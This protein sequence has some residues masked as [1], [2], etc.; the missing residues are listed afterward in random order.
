MMHP[1][2]ILTTKRIRHA[3]AALL[4]LLLSTVTAQALDLPL[5]KESTRIKE[6]DYPKQVYPILIGP[7]GTDSSK[8][9]E[10]NAA[11]RLNIWRFTQN[12]P[13]YQLSLIWREA[14]EAQGFETLYNCAQR[15]CGGYDF[16]RQLDLALMPDLPVDLR[17][18]AYLAMEGE[19]GALTLFFAGIGEAQRVALS[20][21][22]A[23]TLGDEPPEAAAPLRTIPH[24]GIS[25]PLGLQGAGR[26]VL[27]GL[28]FS[29]G[30]ASVSDPQNTLESLAQQLKDTPEQRIALVGHSDM[31]GGYEGNLRLSRARAASVAQLLQQRYGINAG[32][33]DVYGVAYLAPIAENATDEGRQMN[34]RVEVV[35]LQ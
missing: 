26:L 17:D 30:S 7:Y 1:F 20:F 16:R 12:I 5:P 21:Y 19:E 34:R 8:L 10:I 13:R 22:P 31:V 25:P 33:I 32:R 9:R 27:Q 23:Q 28:E 6:V 24:I 3:S 15:S 4:A 29:S 14:L 18:F 2:L 35:F 11:K